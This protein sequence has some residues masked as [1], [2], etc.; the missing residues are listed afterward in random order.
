MAL[1]HKVLAL[2]VLPVMLLFMF[3]TAPTANAAQS[4]GPLF[5]AGGSVTGVIGNVH[6]NSVGEVDHFDVTD[7]ANQVTTITVSPPTSA[8]T[9]LITANIG[10][11]VTVEYHDS[12]HPAQHIFDGLTV[13]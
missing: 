6:Y 11:K 8:V 12:G 1:V 7:A 9:T 2:L 5:L 4:D 3:T 13:P 10:K